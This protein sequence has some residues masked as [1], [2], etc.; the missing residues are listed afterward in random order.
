MTLSPLALWVGA[1]LA[2]PL[3][4]RELA[5]ES[6]SQVE[7]TEAGIIGLNTWGQVV[8]LD[9]GLGMIDAFDTSRTTWGLQVSPD[10]QLVATQVWRGR[11]SLYDVSTGKRVVKVPKAT[12]WS[13][14]S[15]LPGVN[16]RYLVIEGSILERDLIGAERIVAD[17]IWL[18]SDEHAGYRDD[19]TPF[20]WEGGRLHVYDPAGE[21]TLTTR[22]SAV[23]IEAV[24]GGFVLLDYDG[25]VERVGLDGERS[26]LHT[27]TGLGAS[28]ITRDGQTLARTDMSGTTIQFID[29]DS[30]TVLDTVAAS[31][32]VYDLSFSPDGERLVSVWM[33]GQVRID[34]V[35]DGPRVDLS[36]SR[37][38]A[39]VHLKVSTDGRRAV[40]VWADGHVAAWDLATGAPLSSFDIPLF[41]GWGVGLVE[42]SA[43]GTWLAAATSRGTVLRWNVDTGESFGPLLPGGES[44]VLVDLAED[45]S[46]GVASA[47]WVRT[48][49]AEGELVGE[50]PATYP[51]AL[52]VGPG[53]VTVVVADYQGSMTAFDAPTG[54]VLASR[55]SDL[56][57]SVP[58]AIDVGETVRFVD[59]VGVWAW[60]L[61][62]GEVEGVFMREAS[63]ASL[64]PGAMA[65]QSW[66][67]GGTELFDEDG[68]SLMSIS[69][70][71]LPSYPLTP[72]LIAAHPT[73]V[74]WASLHGHVHWS[75]A[76][77]SRVLTGAQPEIWGVAGTEDQLVVATS[78]GTYALDDAVHELSDQ[79]L[80]EL[81]VLDGVVYGRQIDG[82]TRAWKTGS[83]ADAPTLEGW[84]VGT[85]RQ[86]GWGADLP[87][88]KLKRRQ[89]NAMSGRITDC[90]DG[91][92][93]LSADMSWGAASTVFVVD[94][95]GK[96]I[97]ADTAVSGQS[98]LECVA[99]PDGV[100]AIVGTSGG[101]VTVLDVTTGEW[102]AGL[103]G[104]GSP[105]HALH[106]SDEGIWVGH[107][108]GA[109]RVWGLDGTFRYE[110]LF[111]DGGT[112]LAH[113]GEGLL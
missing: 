75:T 55:A 61:Q 12:R 30:G 82:T 74:A 112:T 99:T 7:W 96:V 109:L 37:G 91:S 71:T 53:G 68:T 60:D 33:D 8:V 48:W 13:A 1:A 44:Q 85:E 94:P 104:D 49:N 98:R 5:S 27:G 84:P 106:V 107:A 35:P 57:A 100:R 65:F 111:F 41:A 83:W 78:R 108:S 19:G 93:V 2:T 102:I 24:D 45:G 40:A 113:D 69:G 16:D 103:P 88:A 52:A 54:E 9:E 28:A 92:R 43:D 66:N 23:S 20:A 70:A 73:G 22:S 36:A 77:E 31:S 58:L 26:S 29:P 4:S 80:L 32:G 79:G 47:S 39:P 18:A 10:G 95:E 97:E 63:L 90:P 50:F 15:V 67:T 59:G 25:S 110:R 101:A 17:G 76:D 105:V 56:Y 3:A 34:S 62:T 81:A 6:I 46:L 42:V 38:V 89:R 86:V 87:G 72:T 64:A 21:R 14:P 11:A 51:G